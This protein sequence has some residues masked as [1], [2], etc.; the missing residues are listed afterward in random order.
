MPETAVHENRLAQ[1]DKS[2]IR[3]ARNIAPMQPISVAE[4]VNNTAHRQLGASIL[5]PYARHD[6][7]AALF[8]N[9]IHPPH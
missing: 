5:A 2:Q 6:L 1:A 7:A 3:S 9:R 4:S 8:R